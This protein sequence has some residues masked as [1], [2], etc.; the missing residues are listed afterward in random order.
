MADKTSTFTTRIFL[1]DQQAKSKLESLEKDIKRLR[2]EQEAAAK[3]GDWTKFEQVKKDLKQANKEMGAMKTS[4]QKVSHVLDNLKTSSIKEIRQTM[5][6][7]NRELK[8]GAVERNS[9]EWKFLNEQLRRCKQE[10]QQV[11]NESKTTKSIWSR[12]MDFLNKNWG[13]FTQIL[14]S[15]TGLSV[16]IRK[17]VSDFAEMDQAMVNVQKYTGQ[18]KE[19]VEEM[20]EDFKT[21]NTR[22]P[23]EQL[24]ELAGAAGRLGIQSKKS[25]E[26]FVDAADKINVALGDDLG[27]GAVDKI[28][29][30]AQVFGEDKTKGLRGA[31]LATGSAVNELAQSSSANA[32]YIVDFAADLAGVGRQAGMSQQEIMGLASALDQN[33][34]EEKTSATV[35]SQ[36]ITKM[37]QDPAKFASIAGIKVKEF[38]KMLKEDANKALLQFMQT[39]QN[40]GGFADLAPMFESMNLDG[41]RA[42]GVLSAVATH[43]DQVREA[44]DTANKAYSSGS[45]VIQE[46]NTQNSSVQAQMD[47][48][49]KEFV[50]VSIALGQELLPVVKYTISGGSLLVKTLYTLIGFTKQHIRTLL[51]LTSTIAIVAAVYNAAYLKEKALAALTVI[52]NGLNKVETFLIKAKTAAITAAKLAYYLLTGQ[53][54]KAKEA[55]LAMRAA[56]IANPYAALA[57][58]ILGLGMVIY[59][60]IAAIREHNKA[61]HDNLL[62]VRQARAAAQDMKEATKEV[63]QSTAEEKLRIERLTN[64]INSNVY[65][66]KERKNAMIALEKIVPGYH[67][68][69]RNEASLTASNNKA[70]K[71]YVE[72]LNDAAMAQALYNRMV[73]LQ[74]KQFDLEKEIQRH[75]NS[76][77]AVQAEINRHPDKYNA[78]ETHY[79]FRGGMAGNLASWEEPTEE[80]TQ[81]HR[82]LQQ[83]IDL[84]KK[85]SDNLSVVKYQIKSINDYMDAHKGVR[86][87]YD[88]IVAN[89][90]GGSGAS[91]SWAPTT[92]GGTSTYVDPKKAAKA[93][94]AAETA[95]KKAEAAAKKHE[96]EMKAATRKAYQEEIKA[97]KGKT[98]EEQAQNI[99]AYSQG[100]K[101]YSEY[102]NDQH[103]I[104]IN[105]Y[106]SLEA[107]YKKYGTDYGQWQDEIAKEEQKKHEDHQKALLSDV[108]INHQREIYS[109]NEDYNDP[110][111]KIYHNEE[112]LNERLFEIDM[113]AMADRTAVLQEGSQEW[114]DS[115]AEMT[116]KEEEHEL[117]LQQH[118]AELL[119]QYREQWGQKDVKDQERI[120]INGLDTLH[121]KGIIKEQ[122]YQEMLHNIKLHYEEEESQNN[123]NNSKGEQFKRNANTAY[124]TASNNAKADYE[125]DHPT[126]TGVGD[127]YTSDVTIY[128]STLANIKKMEQQGVVSHQEAM[129][130]M[131][132]ATADMCNGLSAKMQAAYDAIS[133]IMSAMSSYYS[134]Q[135]DYEVTVTEKKYDKMIEKAGNNSAKSK[136]LEEK[137]QKEV[138]KIKTKY[139]KKQMKM[140]IAQ[141]IAQTA[142]SAIAAYGSAMSGVPYPAN[143]VLAPIAAGIA[144]AAGAIQIATIKKQQQA[145]EAGYYEGGFTGGNRYRREAGVVHEGEFVANHNAV[146]NPQ[147]LPALR[148]IDVAQ[149]NNTVGRLTASDVTRAMGV[150]GATVVS[151]PTVNVQTDNSELAD[152]LQQA[153]KTMEKIGSLLDGGITANVSMENF[154]K[155]EK[156][157]DQI[158]KNK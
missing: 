68:N 36:L 95:R 11:N 49:K 55:M 144:L 2:S 75:E 60:V 42:V 30:L 129:A 135:S 45:S 82:E 110:N 20:N 64:I 89:G 133:P 143:L 59:K 88:K 125:N 124:Q 22:T 19:Q 96:N 103:D 33:M 72:R 43:L 24:N 21:M 8:S 116:Q 66:Y 73:A 67:R 44:Q 9:R 109:A 4:A 3:A 158:Q 151:A 18:T 131:S 32:G 130:A 107:I 136:K 81:K 69:L 13:A 26:E 39:M 17:S 70:L 140:E 25:I 134:A 114:L 121:E 16:A 147:L 101:K 119:S 28:G 29:K 104:A 97:A 120:A 53:I 146:N 47:M 154:K 27:E 93:A 37:Y 156:H 148:L 126:G 118:Y 111:S 79:S 128:A 149:R 153:R 142:M 108:E 58:V 106:K 38:S 115:K 117:Y 15:I 50:E 40:K 80:N 122:E 91:P 52:M 65:S 85:A 150:G 77:K 84:S 141:A 56:S 63:N 14:G 35:F 62:S 155:Q 105:G 145:Q 1:N 10:L 113:A 152:T 6:A 139:A 92:S 123:L 132:Q 51:T 138:A 157:W 5:G 7:I 71:E 102:L 34:Q 46:F 112:A 78:T 41:T 99:M 12:G 31:M 57:A 83:W 90:S 137:K 61:M 76:R 48:A 86:I 54:K 100:K 23:R 98:D 94:K 87:A 74:G 127:Y